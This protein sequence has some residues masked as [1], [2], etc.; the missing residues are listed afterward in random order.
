MIKKINITFTL[1]LML[2]LVS[3]SSGVASPGLIEVRITD[4]REAIGDFDRLDIIIERVGF[5]PAGAAR[6]E[7]WID[8]DPDTAIVDLTQV[9]DGTTVSVLEASLPAGD[10]DAVRLHITNGEGDLKIGE[11][12]MVSGFEQAVRLPFL[13]RP[14][15]RTAIIFDIVVE[16]EDDH[17]GGGYEINILN[18]VID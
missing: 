3:C 10:Y 14:D 8:L 15:N 7:G 12:V 17:P 13:I 16:S 5:H 9:L 4:H 6:T 11:S 1:L 18:A 2:L